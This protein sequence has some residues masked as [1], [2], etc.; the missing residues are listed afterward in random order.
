MWIQ[1]RQRC[2][3]RTHECSLPAPTCLPPII[4]VHV[5]RYDRDRGVAPTSSHVAVTCHRPLSVSLDRGRRRNPRRPTTGVTTASE[6]SRPASDPRPSCF[7]R[8]AAARS[9]H[10]RSAGLPW[11]L[12]SADHLILGCNWERTT[13]LP[14]TK[15]QH[16]DE[17]SQHGM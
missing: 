11:R 4:C 1:T 10:F 13:A 17:P 2:R 6:L 16:H 9:T 5:S 12:Q 7:A 14:S 3:A 15:T 8:R